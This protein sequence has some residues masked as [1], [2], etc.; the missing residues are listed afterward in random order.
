MEDE[1]RL[2]EI[3]IDALYFKNLDPG[4]YQ[5]V[6]AVER[7]GLELSAAKQLIDQQEDG[8]YHPADLMAHKMQQHIEQENRRALTFLDAEDEKLEILFKH[9]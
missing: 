4:Q 5:D 3:D 6:R 9:Y 8:T 1:D 7:E 2:S